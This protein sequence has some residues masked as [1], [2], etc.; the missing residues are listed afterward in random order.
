VVFGSNIRSVHY[1]D[2]CPTLIA[3]RGAGIT[4]GQHLVQPKDTPLCNLWLTL[5]KGSGIE[6]ELFGN[7]TGTVRDLVGG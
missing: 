6:V 5:L 3:G 2:N 7:S 4:L 1:L